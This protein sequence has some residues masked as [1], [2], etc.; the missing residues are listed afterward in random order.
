M[1]Q[2]VTVIGAGIAGL[3]CAFDL[4]R[5]GLEVQVLESRTSAGGVM[6]T[7]QSEGFQF[8]TGPNSIPS[9]AECFR[10]LC[11]D[12]GIGEKLVSSRPAART[13]FL[14]ADGRLQAL[15]MKPGQ[16]LSS[17]LLS[18]GAKLRL[19][20]EGFRA[21]RP[22]PDDDDPNFESFLTERFGRE[23]A[24]TFG[25]SFVRGVYAS[26]IQQLGTASAFPK[27]WAMVREHGG[28]LRGIRNKGRARRASGAAASSP[29]LLSLEGGLGRL[30]AALATSLGE[31]L[32]L[33]VSATSVTS[34]GQT[35]RVE[36]DDGS[37]RY[38]DHVVLATPAGPTARL[39]ESA[40]VEHEA[41]S[42]V[43][44]ASVCV[45]HLGFERDFLPDGFGF[46]VP[47][48]A[49]AG[50]APTALG[51]L[52][53]SKMFSGRTPEGGGAISAIF[54]SEQVAG[55]EDRE[56]LELACEDL[57]M[58]LPR[59]TIPHPV[60]AL[61][62][63][64]PDAIPRYAPGHAAR[65]EH[66]LDTLSTAQPELHLVGNFTGGVSIDERIRCGRECARQLKAAMPQEGVA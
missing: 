21:W 13:R 8:E 38:C 49:P 53:V 5:A 50:R 16:L 41:L 25:G 9:S 43:E 56:I 60:T 54:R 7:V 51:V 59:E 32:R 57:R 17:S 26:E 62:Q 33:G 58:A 15:P 52:F 37:L 61:V 44:H 29:D 47:P 35:W 66:L 42:G 63:R 14:F 1:N 55:K 3:S 2:T 12:A 19:L 65:I 30:P 20:T 22:Q 10:E 6:G 40:G 39:L 4:A 48:D 31:R 34:T 23:I 28:V 46:L 11:F 24:R 36:L 64:W 45:V 18:W 27:L